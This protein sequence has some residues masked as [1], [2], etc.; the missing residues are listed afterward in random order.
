MNIVAFAE[1]HFPAVTALMA[2]LQDFEREL[3]SDRAP[4][5]EMAAG[6]LCYLIACC[7]RQ[8]GRVLVAESAAGV[9]LGFAVVMVEGCEEGD[10]HVR[11][12]F[13]RFGVVTDLCVRAASRRGG[14]A[15]QL[16]AAAQA[17]CQDLGLKR[18]RVSTLAANRAAR[19]FY[20][21]I[22]FEPYEI[23]YSRDL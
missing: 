9:V 4:G 11:C 8:Q 13:K 7:A 1:H 20:S 2:E 12:E 10:L 14:V 21:D 18:L 15:R 19:A 23:T 5:A 16:M 17:H 22:G 6:H 3:E